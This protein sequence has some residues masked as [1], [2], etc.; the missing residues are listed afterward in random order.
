MR[1]F[2]TISLAAMMSFSLA[3]CGS[4]KADDKETTEKTTTEKTTTMGDD[5]EKD[6]ADQNDAAAGTI[7]QTLLADFQAQVEAGTTGAQ[8]LADGV[9]ANSVIEFKGMTMA[10]EAGY[11]TG[12]DEEIHGFEE[13]VMFSPM[14]GSIPFVGYVF[15]LAEDADADA[16]VQMLKDKANPRWNICTEADE[17]IV[18]SVEKTVFFLMCPSSFEE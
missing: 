4:E 14:I 3:A 9:L 6:T 16:F 12:F 13:G 2:L 5:V 8:E 15:T 17:T 11:L 18:E 7:G 1:K 10:V